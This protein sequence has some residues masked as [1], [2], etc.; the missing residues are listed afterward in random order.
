[1]VSNFLQGARELVP[2]LTWWILAILLLAFS[3]LLLP[4]SESP[5]FFGA[6]LALIFWILRKYLS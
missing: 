5:F 1:M 4:L 2:T 3:A 6:S